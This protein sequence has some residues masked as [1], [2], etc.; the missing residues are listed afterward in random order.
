ME[1]NGGRGLG[2]LSEE[3]LEANNKDIRAF[4][5]S[6]SRK[7]SAYK[8]L[9]DTLGRSLERSD[10]QIHKEIQS[11]RPPCECSVCG[12]IGHTK[13]SCLKSISSVSNKYDS[14]VQSIL[15]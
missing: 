15:F 14:L 1:E 5:E 4:M 9:E 2:D 7:T 10:P 6:F 13:R 11:F 8:Q 3:A 12:Q